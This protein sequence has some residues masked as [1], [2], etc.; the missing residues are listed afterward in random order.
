MKKI[1]FCAALAVAMF[2]GG[3]S[4]AQTD[5][6][7]AA[8]AVAAREKEI[9]EYN[10][11]KADLELKLAQLSKDRRVAIADKNK[12]LEQKRDA[13]IVNIKNQIKAL[14]KEYEITPEKK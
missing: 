3:L 14:N 5:A 9:Q 4:Y 6:E 8:A 13:D 2:L 1:M 12:S 10:E 7:A 11:K